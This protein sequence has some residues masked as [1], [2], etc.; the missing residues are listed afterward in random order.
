[1]PQCN[2]VTSQ[3]N[4]PLLPNIAIH[5][6]KKGDCR[7]NAIPVLSYFTNTCQIH[8]SCICYHKRS[9]YACSLVGEAT[10]AALHLPVDQLCTL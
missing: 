8:A 6:N 3:T 4:A 1:M 2:S 10:L 5:S 9:I 7:L